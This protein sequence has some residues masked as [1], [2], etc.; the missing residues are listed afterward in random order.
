MDRHHRLNQP[1]RFINATTIPPTVIALGFVIV[2]VAMLIVRAIS[3][4]AIGSTFTDSRT[5]KV[6]GFTTLQ[7]TL[8]TLTT[9]TLGIIPGLIIARS[10]FRGRQLVLS[11]FAAVFVMPTVV[12]AAGGER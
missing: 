8:S 7:A 4:D 1:S 9:V 12:M 10:D 6:L 3:I 2:P 5:W 11:M